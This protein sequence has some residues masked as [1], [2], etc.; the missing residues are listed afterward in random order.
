MP[1]SISSPSGPVKQVN[2]I[3]DLPEVHRPSLLKRRRKPGVIESH[4]QFREIER[5]LL[6]GKM[7]HKAIAKKY[8]LV[9][10]TL[11]LYWQTQLRPRVRALASLEEQGKISDTQKK[12]GEI[13]E[14]NIGGIKEARA[15]KKYSELASLLGRGIEAIEL[16]ARVRQEIDSKAPVTAA[17]PNQLNLIML[18]KAGDRYEELETI[19]PLLPGAT[20]P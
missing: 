6:I 15:D 11:S 7:G 18:P 20:T 9:Y 2:S 16:L 19:L 14:E 4:P 13:W 10:K 3:S 8:G 12:L 5:E 1:P 17:P